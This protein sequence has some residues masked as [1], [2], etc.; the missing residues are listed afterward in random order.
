[1]LQYMKLISDRIQSNIKASMD[2]A[3]TEPQNLSLPSSQPVCGYMQHS[4]TR[5]LSSFTVAY[6]RVTFFV[7]NFMFM[8]KT[9]GL[10]SFPDCRWSCDVTSYQPKV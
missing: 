10:S 8:L 7:Y 2:S 3:A 6:K 4:P 1:M 9:L 5:A